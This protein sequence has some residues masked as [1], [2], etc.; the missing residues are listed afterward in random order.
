MMF[1]EFLYRHLKM[2]EDEKADL[3]YLISRNNLRRYDYEKRFNEIIGGIQ[4]VEEQI[5]EERERQYE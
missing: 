4:R 1:L 2:L 5:Q 3:E